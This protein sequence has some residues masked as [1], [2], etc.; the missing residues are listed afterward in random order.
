MK[1]ALFSSAA[2]KDIRAILEYVARDNVP[3]ALKLIADIEDRC[4][5]LATHPLLG[6]KRDHIHPGLRVSVC[7]GYSIYYKPYD[8]TVWISRVLHPS[9]NLRP[10]M[11]S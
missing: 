10:D 7:R 1:E 9:L 3:A 5:L 11:F 6:S 2:S 4:C 8:N